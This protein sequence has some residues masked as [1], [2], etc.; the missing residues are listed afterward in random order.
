MPTKHLTH[1]HVD[2][3][4]WRNQQRGFIQ[5]LVKG[6]FAFGSSRF[7]F[8]SLEYSSISW[9]CFVITDKNFALAIV[10]DPL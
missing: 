2:G 7:K 6:L 3:Q 1:V 4:G 10:L 5:K 9:Q 8:A